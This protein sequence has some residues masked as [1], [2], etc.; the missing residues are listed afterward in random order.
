MINELSHRML[1]DDIKLSDHYIFI[2][3]SSLVQIQ[4]FN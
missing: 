1:K 3:I 4:L 2:I